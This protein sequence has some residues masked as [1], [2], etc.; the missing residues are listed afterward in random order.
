MVVRNALHFVLIATLAASLCYAREVGAEPPAKS[1]AWLRGE[2]RIGLTAARSNGFGLGQEFDRFYN[3]Y[4]AALAIG[5]IAPLTSLSAHSHWFAEAMLV[6]P[7]YHVHGQF[8]PP[9]ESAPSRSVRV[10][11]LEGMLMARYEIRPVHISLG[12]WA[13][14]PLVSTERVSSLSVA[15]GG[16]VFDVGVE[17]PLP[18]VTVDAMLQPFLFP[19]ASQD[20]SGSWLHAAI[21]W[22]GYTW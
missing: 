5:A 22:F 7:R 20:G 16:P 1:N 12:A 6:L 4:D 19:F 11:Y 9:S 18:G 21:L 17:L 13:G 3:G 15:V 10:L 14:T 8:D 2:V